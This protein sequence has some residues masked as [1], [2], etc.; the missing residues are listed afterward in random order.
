VDIIVEDNRYHSLTL[1]VSVATTDVAF[2]KNKAK[3]TQAW[4]CMP[5][6]PAT[7][8]IEA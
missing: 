8:G 3:S 2:Y 4:Y 6:I 1:C 7:Q 5:V